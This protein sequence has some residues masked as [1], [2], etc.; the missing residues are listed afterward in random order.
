MIYLHYRFDAPQTVRVTITNA[1]GMTVF[2]GGFSA[3]NTEGVYEI[4]TNGWANVIYI[5]ATTSGGVKLNTEK[6]VVQR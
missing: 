6:I 1:S 5:A 4:E 3:D 2:Y